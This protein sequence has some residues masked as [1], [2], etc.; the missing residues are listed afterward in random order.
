MAR[1]DPQWGEISC[2]F[3]ILRDG[4]SATADELIEHCRQELARFKAPRTLVFG[5]LPQISTGKIQ[6]FPLREQA[7]GL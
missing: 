5:P 3:L 4:A 2:A 7:K 1:P 6:I